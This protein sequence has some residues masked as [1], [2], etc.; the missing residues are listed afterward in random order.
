MRKE[1]YDC[2]ILA[3][4]IQTFFGVNVKFCHRIRTTWMVL[5][6]QKNGEQYSVYWQFSLKKPWL[7]PKYEPEFGE[8]KV[9]LYGW[10]FFYFGRK[11]E[12]LFA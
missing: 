2:R 10:L 11:K 1:I 9:P 4:I 6:N 3:T 7:L 12:H 8:S 5:Y